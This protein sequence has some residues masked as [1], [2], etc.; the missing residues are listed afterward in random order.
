MSALVSCEFDQVTAIGST[1]KPYIVF[2]RFS[3]QLNFIIEQARKQLRTNE[4]KN[5]RKNTKKTQTHADN[6]NPCPVNGFFATFTG[7]GGGLKYPQAYLE[8]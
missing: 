6:I 7:N 3:T 5:T 4:E 2:R 1:V 8:F